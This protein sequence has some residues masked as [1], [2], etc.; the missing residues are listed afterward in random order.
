MAATNGSPGL[1]RELLRHIGL[2]WRDLQHLQFWRL[3]TSQLA[4]TTAGFVWSNVALLLIVLPI[5][6]WRL[7]TRRTI[8][9]FFLGDWVSTLITFVG[10][11]VISPWSPW[12]AHILTVRDAGPS[13]GAW[14][15]A[16]TV[17]LTLRPRRTRRIVST[18]L[19][20]FLVISVVVHTR[21]FDVQHLLAAV[22]AAGGVAIVNASRSGRHPRRQHHADDTNE[23][24]HHDRSRPKPTGPSPTPPI[25]VAA[26]A[27]PRPS[28]TGQRTLERRP[29]GGPNAGRADER[30]RDGV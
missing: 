9:V 4:E 11:R 7:G 22:A 20:A 26:A 14:A 8:L 6:E 28:T 24:S 15:L 18:G 13:S 21:L 30:P 1:H 12:A 16:I 3:P 25:K 5:A 17:A 23:H 19:F 2:A 29:P 27:N 10:L